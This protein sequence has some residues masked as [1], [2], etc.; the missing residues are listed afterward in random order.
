VV[1]LLLASWL[2]HPLAEGH[3]STCSAVDHSGC[4][5][6][7]WS[8]VAGDI[9]ELTILTAL[10]ASLLAWWRKHNCHVQGC[11]R[12]SWHPH[13]GHG[14]PVCRKH[15]PYGQGRGAHLRP[16]FHR[17]HSGWPTLQ[18]GP[19][20]GTASVTWSEAPAS[21]Y[22]ETETPE[23]PKPKRKRVRKPGTGDVTDIT[24][25]KP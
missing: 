15:H 21:G 12:L 8:G 13:P 20:L 7:F 22:I 5:Y 19:F 9:A 18:G 23:P 11:W 10:L 16:E 2:W 14:H 24:S 6:S 4:G 1:H 3:G 17:D 25:K